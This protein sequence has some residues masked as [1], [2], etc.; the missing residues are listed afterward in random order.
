MPDQATSLIR[1]VLA[2]TGGEVG[3]AAGVSVAVDDGVGLSAITDS[4]GTA[5]GLG[6]GVRVYQALAE[7]DGAGET[8]AVSVWLGEGESVGLAGDPVGDR[9]PSRLAEG[10]GVEEV[11]GEG[12]SMV[13]LGGV[14]LLAVVWVLLA[15]DW[16]ASP[17]WLMGGARVSRTNPTATAMTVE[18]RDAAVL[19]IAF[20]LGYTC[21]YC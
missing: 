7:T 19:C 4:V 16:G 15:V 3:G 6:E 14:S 8:L 18:R 17:V 10:E 1:T 5:V 9:D 20:P 11:S 2:G 12:E 13:V 21:R